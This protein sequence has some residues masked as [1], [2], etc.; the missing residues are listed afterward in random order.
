MDNLVIWGYLLG[1]M[2][3]G[4]NG[5]I[6]IGMINKHNQIVLERLETNRLLLRIRLNRR[7]L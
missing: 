3:F 1:L 5:L 4:L 7:R 2:V 6:M